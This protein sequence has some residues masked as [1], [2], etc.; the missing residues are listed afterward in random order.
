MPR[1]AEM[2]QSPVPERLE[3]PTDA[4]PLRNRQL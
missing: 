4:W 2:R 1:A 3:L